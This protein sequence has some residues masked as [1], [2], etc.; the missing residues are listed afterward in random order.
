MHELEHCVVQ[1]VAAEEFVET[2]D[3]RATALRFRR[4]I[5]YAVERHDGRH[6]RRF[7]GAH[8][9]EGDQVTARGL[10]GDRDTSR[11]HTIVGGV[12]LDPADGGL[13][14]LDRCRVAMLRREPI[15]DGEPGETRRDEGIVHRHHVALVFTAI[16]VTS[17]PAAAM[18]ENDGRKWPRA[19]GHTSVELQAHASSSAIFDVSLDG[20]LGRA[21]DAEEE[22]NGSGEVHWIGGS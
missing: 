3:R 22:K 5:E 2:G 13:D 6:P 9:G 20:G 4:E 12:G 7:V 1:C 17:G 16:F 10:A 18:H 21:G 15:V 11:V 19:I 14:I 8:H